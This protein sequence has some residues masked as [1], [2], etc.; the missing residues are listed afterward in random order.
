MATDQYGYLYPVTVD[1][2]YGINGGPIEGPTGPGPMTAA[3][4]AALIQ[5]EIG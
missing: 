1:P 3:K 4:A 5:K 2:E